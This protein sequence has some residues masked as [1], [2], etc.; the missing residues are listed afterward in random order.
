[1]W[2]RR[3]LDV[4]KGRKVSAVRPNAKPTSVNAKSTARPSMSSKPAPSRPLAQVWA[5]DAR[6]TM[7]NA[8]SRFAAIAS[9]PT[10]YIKYVSNRVH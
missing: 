10:N 6:S 8:R 5:E 4:L 9:V 1:M 2:S 7:R 3:S